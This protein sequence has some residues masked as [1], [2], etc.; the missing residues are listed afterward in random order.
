MSERRRG[1]G[2]AGAPHGVADLRAAGGTRTDQKRQAITEAATGLF[3]RQG[4]EGTSM[5]EIAAAAAVSKQTVYKQFTD[6]EQLFATIVTAITERAERIAETI[7]ALVDEIV[8]L[9]AGLVQLARAYTTAV[10]QP[11]VVQLRRL[12]I[13]EADRFPVLARTY[14]QRAPARGIA[15]LAGGLERLAGRQLLRIDDATTAAEQFA[16]LV[17]G[18]VID[19]ALFDPG[20]PI[21]DSEIARYAAAG[22]RVF[23]AAYT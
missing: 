11:P 3:L 14:Y 16:Y 5:D 7:N 18:P 19:R 12:V 9:E 13:S 10:V 8:D 1:H 6:K 23:V 20:A 17:L 2:E 15:A 4:Y 21:E 22:V